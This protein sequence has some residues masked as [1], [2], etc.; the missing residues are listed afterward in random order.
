MEIANRS[1]CLLAAPGL[2]HPILG[3]TDFNCWPDM[4]LAYPDDAKAFLASRWLTTEVASR[5]LKVPRAEVRITRECALCGSIAHGRPRSGDVW[6]SA[7]RRR[8]LVAA[9]AGTLPIAVDLEPEEAGAEVPQSSLT[10]EERSADAVGRLR[11]WTRKECL[12]KL[13][14][15]GIDDFASISTGAPQSDSVQVGRAHL[16]SYLMQGHMVTVASLDGRPP[17]PTLCN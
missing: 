17:L 5:L 6:L 13:G 16:K 4:N 12:V 8:R 7:S 3:L 2:I 11:V 14:L 15:C 10:R 1:L 9:A